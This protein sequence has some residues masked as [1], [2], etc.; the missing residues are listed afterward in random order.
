MWTRPITL[1]FLLFF[2][3]SSFVLAPSYSIGKPLLTHADTL[4]VLVR[5][6]DVPSRSLEK[7]HTTEPSFPFGPPSPIMSG[8]RTPTHLGRGRAAHT[9]GGSWVVRTMYNQQHID[10]LRLTVGPLPPPTPP[11]HSPPH[12]CRDSSNSHPRSEMAFLVILVMVR[13][14]RL[15]VTM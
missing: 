2:A 13:G 3:F 15:R 6:H 12:A 7:S 1:C 11:T 14:G 9:T 8:I 10:A 4:S 5:L